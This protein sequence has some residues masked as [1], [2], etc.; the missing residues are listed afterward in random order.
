M[1]KNDIGLGRKALDYINANGTEIAA[2]VVTA[3]AVGAVAYGGAKAVTTAG[4][5]GGCV[6]AALA[7]NTIAKLTLGVGAAA[8]ADA[9]AKVKHSF[10]KPT[11]QTQPQAAAG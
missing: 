8:L 4:L 9:T 7:V 2:G 6:F 5:V 11:L 3:A 10:E 1:D